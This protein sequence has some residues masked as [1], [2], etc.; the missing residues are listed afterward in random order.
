MVDHLQ[1][2]DADILEGFTALTYMAALRPQ[3]KFGHTVLCQ[4]FRNPA[5]LA[6]WAR[7]C[8]S[9]AAG[10]SFSA[11]ARVGTKKNIGPMVT[12]SLPTHARDAT[13]GS[14]S[15]HQSDVGPRHRPPSRP[16]L[17]GEPRLLRA[18]AE[19]STTIMVGAFRPRMLRLT[20]K[21]A[22]GGTCHRPGYADTRLVEAFEQA[23]AKWAA[24]VYG[25]ALL[26]WRVRLRTYTR[27]SG[28]LRRRISIAL[29]TLRMISASV[30]TPQR[31]VEQMRP[32]L[33]WAWT[34]SCSTVE[35]FP[36]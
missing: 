14:A 27:G 22:D 12:I 10:A 33:T 31:L 2:G 15:N 17:P 7:P 21:Y 5:L 8:S 24:S 30:G 32:S 34:I 4:S 9:S 20:A 29:R 26:G 36:S 16:V 19:S 13:R 11:S 3:L 18:Q 6:R 28:T 23:C 1:F 35:V 25:E